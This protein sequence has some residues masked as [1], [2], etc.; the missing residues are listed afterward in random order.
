MEWNVRVRAV[1]AA[2]DE[3]SDEEKDQ[4]RLAAGISQHAAV[5]TKEP[6]RR[7]TVDMSEGTHPGQVQPIVRNLMKTLLEDHPSLLTETDI[8]DLTNRDYTQNIL[9]L[10][11]GG[12]SLLRRK[13]AGRTGSNN[14]RHNRFYAKLYADRFYVCSQWWR[15]DH[16]DNA[17]SLLRLVV[18]IAHR[19]PDHPGI[20]DLERYT[21]ALE[22]YIGRT[23]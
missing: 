10:Q 11:L 21:R 22:N 8:E 12:F 13:E 5:R 4:F 23:A 20:P 9:G 16:L 3:L 7:S 14:D 19:T 6:G 17:K 15:D 1:L 2:Y 18:E